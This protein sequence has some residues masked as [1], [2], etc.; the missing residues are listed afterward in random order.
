MA[1]DIG[2]VS[3]NRQLPQRWLV[4]LCLVAIASASS[5]FSSPASALAAGVT[6]S[7][8]SPTSGDVGTPVVISGSGFTGATKV[9]FGLVA[10]TFT[11]VSDSTIDTSVPTDAVR[12]TIS[13]H[14]PSGNVTTKHEYFK[15]TP[16]ITTV[17][18]ANG[19]AGTPVTIVGTA[20]TDDT[21]VAFNGTPATVDTVSYSQITTAVPAGAT[22]GPV[23]VTTKWGSTS[24]LSTFTVLQV[25]D[26]TDYGA[27][28]DGTG[29]NTA[30]FA[31][32]IAAAQAA[33]ANSIV[34]VPAGTY[35]F[36]TGSPASI[37]IDG[38]VPITLEGAGVGTTTLQETTEKRDLLSIKCDWTVVEDLTLDTQTYNG[39]HALGDGANYTT[40][41]DIQVLSGTNT[42]GI[43]Y[44]GP[45]GAT[46][47][48]RSYDYGN[49]VNDLTLNDH[50]T[51]DGWSFSFQSGAS[52]SN[53]HHTG[54]RITIYADVSIQITNYYY[55]PGAYGATAGFIL[56][57]PCN[58]VTITNFESSG[59]GGQLKTAPDQ[60]R[61]NQNI[62]INGEVM[63]GGP[64]F[65]LLIGDVEGLLIENSTLD[66]ITID[67]KIIAQGT[68]TSST[69][70]GVINRPQGTGVND[71]VFE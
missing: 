26:V 11:V 71:I 48:N 54:S 4:S 55:T 9:L 50:Y 53:V 6:V 30:A 44:P 43:Y 20:L 49:V 2:A 27:V 10:A 41:Q 5:L 33:G 32:A 61:I 36:S 60:S 67:P 29:D 68:V 25:F 38:T 42:F 21:Q 70:T 22:S 34:S 40:V 52:I 16:S 46:P 3:R 39:G 59:E 65:R 66:G 57:T 17:T 18:P 64:S 69:Y 45:P 63:T 13:V 28:G 47:N 51:G 56:S 19:D 1:R 14:T 7:G 58:A 24:S 8:F 31:A 62:T 35:T 23:S 12:A 15:V 37:Q